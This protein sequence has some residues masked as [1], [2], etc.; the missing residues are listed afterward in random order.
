MMTT[1][2]YLLKCCDDIERMAVQLFKDKHENDFNKYGHFTSM[3]NSLNGIRSYLKE[4]GKKQ[5][6]ENGND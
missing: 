1:N 3:M 2:E 4:D 5:G 6:P